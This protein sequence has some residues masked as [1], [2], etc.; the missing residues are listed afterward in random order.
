MEEGRNR[1][2][3]ADKYL[4]WEGRAPGKQL[5]ENEW[6]SALEPLPSGPSSPRFPL[7]S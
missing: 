2:R 7:A 6:K 4:K 1:D 5:G 3:L